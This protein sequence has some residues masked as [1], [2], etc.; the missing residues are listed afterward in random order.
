MTH[1]NQENGAEALGNLDSLCI[2]SHSWHK[3]SDHPTAKERP[4]ADGWRMRLHMEEHLGARTQ[5]RGHPQS[6][7]PRSPAPATIL[8]TTTW[9]PEWEK[10][11]KCPVEPNK[12]TEMGDKTINCCLKP[13]CMGWLAGHQSLT[14]A[15]YTSSVGVRGL[16]STQTF[17][18]PCWYRSS[19]LV[20]APLVTCDLLY[21]S[22]AVAREERAAG[23]ILTFKCFHL[24]SQSTGQWEMWGE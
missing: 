13:F 8:T 17:M 11:K 9:D 20:S 10:Q 12:H 14:E 5:Q 1:F 21:W 19:H 2:W 23:C 22:G 7:F 24:C 6:S 16:S 3:K 4:H 15:W 18:E